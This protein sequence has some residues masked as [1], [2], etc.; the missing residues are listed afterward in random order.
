MK[1]KEDNVKLMAINTRNIY[2]FSMLRPDIDP[3][4]KRN[5]LR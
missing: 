4:E 2:V 3:F 1:S 5:V